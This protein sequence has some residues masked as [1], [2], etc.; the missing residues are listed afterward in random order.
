MSKLYRVSDNFR[1]LEILS[2][3]I[4]SETPKQIRLA[5][6]NAVY[7]FRNRISSDQ[8]KGFRTEREA[9]DTFIKGEQIVLANAQETIVMC[10]RNIKKA[11]RLYR[12]TK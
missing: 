5:E 2:V 7:G 11:Q 4:E 10:R 3:E 1:G 9:I 6:R 12:E 8:A